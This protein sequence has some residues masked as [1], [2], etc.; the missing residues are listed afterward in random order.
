MK[1]IAGILLIVCCLAGCANKNTQPDAAME[2]RK[3]LLEAQTC[4]FD[5]TVTADY[6]DSL[7]EFTLSCEA[8][9]AGTLKF[10]VVSPE[11]I[12]GITGEI[13]ESS[14]ALTFNDTVLAFPLLADGQMSPVAA[15]WVFLKALRG[16]YLS[17]CGKTDDGFLISVDDSYEEDPLHL[18]VYTDIQVTPVTAEI[19]WQQQCVLTMR[20]QN[21]RFQ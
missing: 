11:S 20:I 1:R 14:A 18:E 5:A 16:G 4:S 3:R 12:S 6:G 2:L 10:T 21:F 9:N 17:G 7:Y 19:Y 13:S 8:D 15:P